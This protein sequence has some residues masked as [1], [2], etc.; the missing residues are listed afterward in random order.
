LKIDALRWIAFD[1]W[2]ADYWLVPGL[3]RRGHGTGQHEHAP[4]VYGMSIA[5]LS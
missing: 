4:H 5:K 3:A 1:P 2:I